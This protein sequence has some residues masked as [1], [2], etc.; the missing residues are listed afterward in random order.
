MR[1]GAQVSDQKLLA[2]RVSQYSGDPMTDPM[3]QPAAAAAAASSMMLD[4]ND[5][6]TEKY[7]KRL[8]QRRQGGAPAAAAMAAPP[9][10]MPAVAT[11]PAT[12]WAPPAFGMPPPVAPLPGAVLPGATG[13]LPRSESMS[14][15]DGRLVDEL[16][17]AL[18]GLGKLDEL[19][20]FVTSQ[21]QA[22][23]PKK[24]RVS[25]LVAKL[26]A[27]LGIEQVA[28]ATNAVVNST[29]VENMLL[30]TLKDRLTPQQR[31]SLSSF[32]AGAGA[33]ARLPIDHVKF[34]Q[35]MVEEAVIV[36][37]LCE[38]VDYLMKQVKIFFLSCDLAPIAHLSEAVISSV[39][40]GVALQAM[41]SSSGFAKLGGGGPFGA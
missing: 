16:A 41:F 4:D 7:R 19:K 6:E 25:R 23:V 2:R 26:V 20:R 39:A 14:D 5:A 18:Q 38:V 33:A 13:V 30:R 32:M 28:A 37:S 27:M 3:G 11:A 9:M 40:V 8:A 17:V 35:S 31:E 36:S 21:Q 1:L 10:G 34:L 15:M 12:S 22:S 29:E 24:E